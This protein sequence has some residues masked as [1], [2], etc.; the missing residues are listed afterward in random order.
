VKKDVRLFKLMTNEDVI[1][2][3]IEQNDFS[4]T[5]KNCIQIM[6][7]PAKTG[8]KKEVNFG[9]VPFPY[10][11]QNTE[12]SYII[13]KQALV[14]YTDN[15]ESDFLE[16]YNQIFNPIITPSSKIILK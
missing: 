13:M 10:Y 11:S 9:F 7:M 5:V 14:F 3:V 1:A 6:M 2:E 8:G 15:I 12:S 16:Q 4:I